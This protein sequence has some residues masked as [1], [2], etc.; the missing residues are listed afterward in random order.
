MTDRDY[1]P[2]EFIAVDKMNCAEVHAEIYDGANERQYI[3]IYE[4][5]DVERRQEVCL[6]RKEAEALRNWLTKVLA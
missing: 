6:D 4:F 2:A 5:E 3:R 1:L